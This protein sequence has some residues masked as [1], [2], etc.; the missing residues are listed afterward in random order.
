MKDG[1][2]PVFHYSIAGFLAGFI[3][4]GLFG[5]LIF[6]DKHGFCAF[7]ANLIYIYYLKILFPPK[8]TEIM[9]E[10]DIEEK[11]N[12]EI[13]DE[14]N[15]EI[16]KGYSS[17]KIKECKDD[18]KEN[19]KDEIENKHF[20]IENYKP[21][22]NID[23]ESLKNENIE[24]K[25]IKKYEKYNNDKNKSCLNVCDHCNQVVGDYENINDKN[26]YKQKYEIDSFFFI[27]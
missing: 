6:G 5:V 16:K 25:Q 13:Y 2:F 23:F 14:I 3:G 15:K 7:S 19:Y 18:E 27:I 11:I 10:K 21:Q 17:T 24:Y 20:E 9:T 4:I 26:K 8:K 1:K 12:N 22:C